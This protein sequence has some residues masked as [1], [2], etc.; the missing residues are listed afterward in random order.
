MLGKEHLPHSYVGLV[1]SWF[2][3][4]L[5]FVFGIFVRASIYPHS[6]CLDKNSMLQDVQYFFLFLFNQL[7]LCGIYWEILKCCLKEK[8]EVLKN[9]YI[10]TR[11][12]KDDEAG[13]CIVWNKN[14]ADLKVN[15]FTN[16]LYTHW[17]P[18]H[19]K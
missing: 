5:T 17:W 11:Q 10:I 2:S 4:F 3:C 15:M 14:F 9:Q 6:Y 16:S 7:G 18:C 13:H 12:S 19:K 8:K 1:M